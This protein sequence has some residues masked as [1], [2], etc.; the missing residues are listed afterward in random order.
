MNEISGDRPG[1]YTVELSHIAKTTTA[2]RYKVHVDD[3]NLSAFAPLVL[4]PAWK[5][6]GDK[7]GIVVEYSLNPAFSTTPV[8]LKNLVLLVS[9][10]GAKAINCQSKPPAVFLKEKS[11]AYWRVGDVTLDVK[12]Q[13]VVARFVGAEGG[14]PLPGMIEA[15]WEI[16][17]PSEHAL[18]SGLGVSRL[19]AGKGKGREESP[20]PFA[21]DSVNGPA[22]VD[23]HWVAVDS[24]RKIVSGKYDAKQVAEE[25]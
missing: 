9:Y 20:D 22:T 4:K 23:G 2:F 5:P 13:K 10:E 17:G 7:L 25:L 8:A 12:P 11:L 16:Q 19:D 18:G 1:E 15:R 14:E 21:D 3:A 6:T 24:A